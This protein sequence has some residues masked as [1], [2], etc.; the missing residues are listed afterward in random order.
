K[1]K[2]PA[3]RHPNFCH[4]LIFRADPY[5]TIAVPMSIIS[6][7]FWTMAVLFGASIP[8]LQACPQ[9]PAQQLSSDSELSNIS[10]SFVVNGRTFD[11]KSYMDKAWEA[12]GRPGLFYSG[13]M[14]WDSQTRQW[15]VKPGLPPD[16]S[17]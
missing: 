11:T 10:R 2:L 8:C 16:F 13:G 9:L 7:C 14:N 3:A 15:Q 6:K 12:K 5:I 4:N 17:K 1:T